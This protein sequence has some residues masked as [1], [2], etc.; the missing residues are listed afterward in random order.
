MLAIFAVLIMSTICGGRE[1][2]KKLGL[3]CLSNLQL[4][5]CSDGVRHPKHYLLYLLFITGFHV[6]RDNKM[7]RHILHGLLRCTTQCW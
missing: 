4:Q 6:M 1:W 7:A 2:R 3:L 5:H